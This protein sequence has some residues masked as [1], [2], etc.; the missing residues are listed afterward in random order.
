MEYLI[1]EEIIVVSSTQSQNNDLFTAE[2]P[3]WIKNNADWWA[4]GFI[5]DEEFILGIEYLIKRGILH[6]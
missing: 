3:T 4:D 5:S 2:I 6:V 1:K